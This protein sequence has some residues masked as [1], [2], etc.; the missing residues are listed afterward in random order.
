MIVKLVPQ[1]LNL[2]WK[3][4]MRLAFA[5][6]SIVSLLTQ[7]C[8]SSSCTERGCPSALTVAL[9]PPLA[10]TGYVV[11]VV[12][13]GATGTCTPQDQGDYYEC[14]GLDGLQVTGHQVALVKPGKNIAITVSDETGVIATEEF[15]P[16]YEQSFP[17]GEECDDGCLIANETLETSN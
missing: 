2:P 13:D 5:L 6:V 15:I 10:G 1:H 11:V 16:E 3:V 14:D 9:S 7:G 12:V 17:N 8:S 4:L